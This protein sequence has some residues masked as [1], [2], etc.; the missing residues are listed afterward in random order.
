MLR[1]IT[2]SG[3]T[4][5]ESKKISFAELLNGRIRHTY[6]N[7][8]IPVYGK[9]RTT[10]DRS[11]QYTEQEIIE[12]GVTAIN[13]A[14]KEKRIT[15]L[16]I[17]GLVF[18]LLSGMV[19]WLPTTFE[20]EE[21]R[22]YRGSRPTFESVE[23]K[24]MN[25]LFR[26]QYGSTPDYS[27]DYAIVFNG[28]DPGI[29][30]LAMS[31]ASM[32]KKITQIREAADYDYSFMSFS[33]TGMYTQSYSVD[34]DL[35]K[36]D[37]YKKAAEE[38]KV[39]FEAEMDRRDALAQPVI[40]QRLLIMA[41]IIAAYLGI[42]YLAVKSCIR[43]GEKR[44]DCIR[45]GKINVTPAI[46]IGRIEYRSRNNHTMNIEVQTEDG[47]ELNIGA[48]GLQYERF[49]AGTKCYVIDYPDLEEMFSKP[50]D[51]IWDELAG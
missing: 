36:M 48:V 45:T 14:K 1:K 28:A 9:E 30:S 2:C 31:I 46:M 47:Q 27:N 41:L 35:K 39:L 18:I 19:V 42:A 33:S 16:L 34:P 7:R 38:A 21:I 3:K 12:R 26:V 11:Y 40:R 23:A 6:R 22:G 32:P 43:N 24:I 13:R 51:L 49:K 5:Q 20:L 25:S 44:L 17:F 10:V 37:M 8:N 15:S 29:S 4:Y 50:R